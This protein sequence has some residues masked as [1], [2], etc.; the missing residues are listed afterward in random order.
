MKFRFIGDP[1]DGGSGPDSV[2]L[3]GLSFGRA[4][5]TEVPDDVAERLKRNNHF[6]AVLT[7][8]PKSK[9]KE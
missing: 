9:A 1:N 6:K 3:F 8:K 2:E 7:T 5:A 4:E